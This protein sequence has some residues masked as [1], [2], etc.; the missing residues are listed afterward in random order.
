MGKIQNHCFLGLL[1]VL[2]VLGT[3]TENIEAS[4]SPDVILTGPECPLFPAPPPSEDS[5]DPTEFTRECETDKDCGD[6][7]LCCSTG[8]CCGKFCYEPD[9]VTTKRPRGSPWG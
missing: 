9:P 5:E 2:L 1:A 4:P 6:G 7:R 3:M 8:A